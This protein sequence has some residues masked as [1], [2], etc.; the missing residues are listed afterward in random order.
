MQNRPIGEAVEEL[1]SDFYFEENGKCVD[2]C[3]W[4][5]NDPQDNYFWVD[6]RWLR[7]FLRQLSLLNDPCNSG[8]DRQPMFTPSN[9]SSAKLVK[10]MFY[11]ILWKLFTKKNYTIPCL[12]DG[13]NFTNEN[14]TSLCR[15][16]A[17]IPVPVPV[18]VP[19]PQRIPPEVVNLPR[20]HGATPGPE[21]DYLSNMMT[22][23]Y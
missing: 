19:V 23:T 22:W 12:G 15:V 14:I 4:S 18:P 3:S 13:V 9:T 11:G 1:L 17:D 16:I 7:R 2:L 21:V 8:V 10:A 5:P 6:I 20:S